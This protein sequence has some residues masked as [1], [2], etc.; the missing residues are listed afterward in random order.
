[1]T[2]TTCLFG[3]E[4]AC[5]GVLAVPGAAEAADALFTD[6]IQLIA[7]KIEAKI[8]GDAAGQ[9]LQQFFVLQDPANAA[10]LITEACTVVKDLF[11]PSPSGPGGRVYVA[12]ASANVIKIFDSLGQAIT[13]AGTFPGLSLPDGMAYDSVTQR[14][15]V[16]N[17][18]NNTVT[19]YDLE[20]NP[21]NLGPTAFAGLNDPE[22]ITFNPANRQFYINEP[23]PSK[24]VV[25]D[26][27]GNPVTLAPTAFAN[28]NQPF[29]LGWDSAN[30]LIYVT[31]FGNNTVTVYDQLGT[32]IQT[33]VGSFAGLNSPDDV[34]WDP[35]TGNLY[36]TGAAE[37][38][39]VC[40]VNQIFVYAPDGRTVSPTGGFPALNGPDAIMSN[41]NASSPIYYVSNICGGS[42]S[43]FD[44]N[45][46]PIQLPVGAFSNLVEPTGLLVVP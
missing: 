38:S 7:T 19:V 18:G 45:G 25:F 1:V 36:I 11:P 4:V 9:L 33:P 43:T 22:D 32:Q 5:A 6:C 17:L 42:V 35:L 8:F 39:G 46:T 23:S 40:S 27:A 13:V 10:N 29:G 2:V 41:G 37:G 24:V 34:S 12:D 16:A 20:G 3:G 44:K 14:I 30:G 21:I 15:Y 28:L 26:E 31:N